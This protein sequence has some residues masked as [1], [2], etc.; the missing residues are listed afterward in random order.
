[1]DC[2]NWKTHRSRNKPN[3]HIHMRT[4]YQAIILTVDSSRFGYREADWRNSFSVG[5]IDHAWFWMGIIRT[6]IDSLDR[7]N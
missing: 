7:P 5:V 2:L 4:G 6:L 1:M 3:K